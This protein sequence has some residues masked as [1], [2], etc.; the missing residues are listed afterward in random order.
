MMQHC[1]YNCENSEIWFRHLSAF[2]GLL[3]VRFSPDTSSFLAFVWAGFRKSAVR[4][5]FFWPN[6]QVHSNVANCKGIRR[7]ETKKA[8][9]FSIQER[10]GILFVQHNFKHLSC[11]DFYTYAY[12]CSQPKL[13]KAICFSDKYTWSQP[14]A[15]SSSSLTVPGS[16]DEAGD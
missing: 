5:G 13:L 10:K 7:H 15:Q 2:L 14:V 4:P 9:K 1:Y 16:Q 12:L 11:R 3:Y 6:L 8:R